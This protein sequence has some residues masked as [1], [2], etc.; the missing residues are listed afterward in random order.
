MACDLIVK[1]ECA[2]KT[3]VVMLASHG[4]RYVNH[5]MWAAVKKEA[6]AALPAPPNMSKD[7]EDVQ[8]KS[9]EYKPEA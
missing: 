5:P 6:T 8:W 9:S 7:I 3:V 2:G 1:D 4:I